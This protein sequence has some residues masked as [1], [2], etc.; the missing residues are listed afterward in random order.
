MGPLRKF[1]PR[2]QG[3][4]AVVLAVVLVLVAA[5]SVEAAFWYED[6]EE[7]KRALAQGDWAAA[8]EYLQSAL[9]TK[10][11][12]SPRTRTYGLNFIAYLPYYKLG[13]AYQELGEFEKAKQAYDASELAGA[14]QGSRNDIAEFERRRAAI[15]EA[16]E[17]P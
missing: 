14:I 9:K 8:I 13:I 12:P 2:L 1:G 6:Y 10:G 11:D 16:A 5:T 7:A 15:E 17:S 3:N 4:S